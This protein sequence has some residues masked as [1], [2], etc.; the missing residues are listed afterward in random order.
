[1]V[2]VEPWPWWVALLGLG[3]LM[4]IAWSI[5]YLRRHPYR[6]DP[7]LVGLYQRGEIDWRELERRQRARRRRS[8]P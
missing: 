8:R 1:V 6:F 5:V 3:C 4:A 7:D 2:I